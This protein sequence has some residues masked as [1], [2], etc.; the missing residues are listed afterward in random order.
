M[1]LLYF[2]F[3]TRFIGGGHAG[4]VAFVNA[5]VHTV[6]YLYYLLAGRENNVFFSASMFTAEAT[7]L[8]YSR[9]KC[10]ARHTV[11]L[12]LADEKSKVIE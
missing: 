12:Q 3:V 10:F 6:M 11:P 7:S 5:G 8:E 1:C 2:W 9:H 4:F